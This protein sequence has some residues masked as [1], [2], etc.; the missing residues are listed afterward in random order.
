MKNLMLINM[1]IRMIAYVL[2]L[3]LCISSVPAQGVEITADEENVLFVGGVSTDAAQYDIP[4]YSG[5]PYVS[6]N[7]GKAYFD[8]EDMTTE[9]F[10]WYCEH[11]ED[12]RCGP[13]YANICTE[14]MPSSE[15]GNISSVSPSGWNNVKYDIIPQKWLFNRCHLIGFQLAGE[16]ANAKNIITGTTYMN[17]S[18]MLPFENEVA[19]YVKETNNHVLYKVTPV[20]DYDNPI[21][22]GVFM[23]AYS[24]EDKG[25]GVNFNVYCYNVQP[26]IYID[27]S[28]GESRAMAGGE[29]ALHPTRLPETDYVVIVSEGTFHKSYCYT[30]DKYDE[31]EWIRVM[32]EREELTDRGYRPCEICMS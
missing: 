30:I 9:P 1:K 13:A 2:L 15:R 23:E 12:G 4:P 18:G 27:Y 6:I 20:Y 19:E 5:E 10:E 17:V 26:G 14:L 16:N 24:V 11:D 28:T 7:G 31:T 21:A 25:E 8:P 29:Y 3:I 32:G 22:N